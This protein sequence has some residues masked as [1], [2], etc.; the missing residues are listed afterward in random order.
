MFHECVNWNYTILCVRRESLFVELNIYQF[1]R[2]FNSA[3]LRIYAVEVFVQGQKTLYEDLI[4][5]LHE[6]VENLELDTYT[7]GMR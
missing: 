4:A 6:L 1:E 5:A 2:L 7:L 3:F